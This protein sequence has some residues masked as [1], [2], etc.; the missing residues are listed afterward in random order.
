MATMT[1]MQTEI[2]PSVPE[3]ISLVQQTHQIDNNQEAILTKF[4]QVL[5]SRALYTPATETGKASHL[6]CDLMYVDLIPR[7]CLLLT[8]ALSHRRF[9]KAR[10]WDIE[11]ATKQFGDVETWR[12]TDRIDELYQ[13][14]DVEEFQTARQYVCF[15][16]SS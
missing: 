12:K 1:T 14:F 4:K 2:I 7:T 3:K 5:Q 8:K 11:G 10:K 9:L 15:P 16:T 6:D 13:N